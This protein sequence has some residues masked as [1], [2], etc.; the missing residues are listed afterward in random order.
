MQLITLQPQRP[1]VRASSRRLSRYSTLLTSLLVTLAAPSAFAAPTACNILYTIQPQNTSAFG[2][3]ITIQ[4]TGTT[5]ISSW[6][7]TWA[8]A[9]GQTISSLWNGA[10]TQSGANVTVNNESYNGSIAA[11]ASLTGIGF[12]G[13]WNGSTNAV[14]TAFSVSGTACSVNGSATTGGTGSFS[15]KP[16]ASTLSIAEGATG[17][18]TVTVTDVSPFSSSVTLAASGLPAG[19]TAS[20]GT[21][22]ATSASVVT[23]TASS[24]ASAGT[25]TVTITGTS[26]TLSATATVALTVTQT[27]QPSFTLTPSASSLSIA[28]GS[29]GS[30]TITV[31]DFGGFTG[32]VSFTATAPSGVTATFS[33][34]SSATSSTITLAASSSASSGTVTVTGTSGTTSA[35]ATIALTVSGGTLAAFPITSGTAYTVVNESNGDCVDDTGGATANGTA[36]EQQVCTAGDINQE[37]LFTSVGTNS[38]EITSANLAGAAWNVIGPSTTPGTGIQLYTYYSG[39][40]NMQ[41]EAFEL[42]SGVAELVDENSKLCLNFPTTTAGQQLQINTCNE[43]VSESFGITPVTAAPRFT[44]ASSAS[45]LSVAQ[46]NSGTDTVTVTD[47][48]GFAGSITLTTSTLPSGVTASFGTNPTSGSS[49][50]TFAASSAAAAG[51]STVTITGVSGSLSTSTS[52]TLT[53]TTTGG[54]TAPN[55]GIPLPSAGISLAGVTSGPLTILNWAGFKAATSWTFDDSQP[56]QIQHYADI[57][58]VGVPVTYYLVSGEHNDASNY[59]ATWT[60]AAEAG[61]E[62]GN[63][64]QDHCQANLTNCMTNT[65]TGNL[66]TELDDDTSYIVSHYPQKA[67]WTGASPYG[68][69]GYDADASTRFLIY[70]GVQGGSMMPNDNTYPFDVPCH[71]AAQGETASQFNAVTDTARSSGAWQIF[72]I[73]TITPTSAV[74]YNPVAVTD[75][76]GAMTHAKTAGDT[77]VDSVVDVGAYWRGLK[78]VAS[79][80]RSTSG[81]TTTWTWTLPANFPTGKYLRVTVP[82]GTLSQ[83]GT[84]ITENSHGFFSVSLDAGS[85]TL[86]Q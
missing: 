18:D 48:N 74:W 34:T 22:P 45:A 82:S 73:H 84:P 6:T 75:V 71:M 21:N 47:V 66:A 11:G 55:D 30:D 72:L 51:T 12:N 28:Q 52:I 85:L 26:G 35:S 27:T 36:V 50:V 46:G 61:D 17:T 86:T 8:F 16:S 2:A 31:G 15:L 83:K 41:F 57:Q 44:L 64:T 20:F 53:V 63:H 59:D 69:T 13:T 65:N 38:W 42:S 62:L 3:A 32:A 80:N 33:P 77:W 43:A 70:R 19:V 23:F 68:D 25:S 4:N 60:A 7:L 39:A 9:N 58:A 40:L 54:G 5:A 29:S 67:V 81:S 14:P 76:T 78:T 1:S 10:E 49:V 56:S 37:W 24:A 79:A